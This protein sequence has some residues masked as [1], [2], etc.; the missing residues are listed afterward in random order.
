MV[1]SLVISKLQMLEK[2]DLAAGVVEII[3]R[4]LLFKSCLTGWGI[5]N[6]FRSVSSSGDKLNGD[7]SSIPMR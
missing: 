6:L 2:L 7:G 4:L 3:F 1:L 5:G